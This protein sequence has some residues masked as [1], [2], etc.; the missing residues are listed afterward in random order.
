MSVYSIYFSPTGG[1]KKIADILTKDFSNCTD[2]DLCKPC[3]N[4]LHHF[5]ED[6]LC[7]IAVPS[8]GGRVPETAAARLKSLSGQHTLAVL[9]VVY[10]NRA[11]EDTLLELSDIVS[12][13]SFLP[14]AAVTAIAEHSI[15][16]QFAANRPDDEDNRTLTD[17]ANQIAAKVHLMSKT[18]SKAGA[19]TLPPQLPG[20][21]P[22][23]KYGAFPFLPLVNNR[24]TGCKKCALLCPVGAIS[25]DCPNE[26]NVAQCIG[27]M[28]CISICPENARYLDSDMLNEKSEKMAPLFAQRKVCE[29]F[30]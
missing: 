15:M 16:H 3:E 2:I 17:F 4:S 8:F 7:Y 11:Y 12:E 30:I 13:C 18:S 24:C 14:V 28:R 9:I 10:G 25:A 21:R 26:T 20:S 19:S 5:S 1:T 6:D 27:C 23:K 22:Y 29:L